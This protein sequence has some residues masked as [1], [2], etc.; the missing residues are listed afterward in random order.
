MGAIYFLVYLFF[1][2]LFSYE[3]ARMFTPFGLFLEI[4]LTAFAGIAIIRSLNFS[5]AQSLQ[6]VMRREITEEE[7]ISIG[8]FKLIGGILIF[9]PGVFSDTVGLLFMFEPFA[10]LFTKKFFKRTTVYEEHTYGNNDTD[11]I[12]VEIIEEIP[13]RD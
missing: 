2:I 9:V 5:M 3:F 7:F 6:R 11:I 12:D 4:I 8:L 10:K 1:E 13:K